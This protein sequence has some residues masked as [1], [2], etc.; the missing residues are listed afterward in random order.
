MKKN[1]GSTNQ[2]KSEKF[3]SKEKGCIQRRNKSGLGREFLE[4]ISLTN[5]DTGHKKP[6]K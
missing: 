4:K 3:T 1:T 2:N 5:K 6:K